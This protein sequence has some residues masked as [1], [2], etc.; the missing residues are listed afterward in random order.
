MKI[1]FIA[2]KYE[3]GDKNRGLSYEYINFYDTLV[4]MNGGQNQVI[5]FPVD[6]SMKE[7]GR[8]G[9]NK[10]LLEV[11]ARERSDLCFFCLSKDEIKQETIQKIT[12]ESGAVTFNWFTD[13]HWRFYNFSRHWAPYFNWVTTTDPKAI[14]KYHN[15]GYKNVIMSQWAC[16]HFLYKPLNLP[17]IYD[18]TFVG[19]PHG[20]RKKIINQIKKAG[21]NIACFGFGWPNGYVSFDQMLQIFSQSSININMTNSS[22][23]GIIKSVASVFFKKNYN[24]KIRLASPADWLDNIKFILAKRR[25]QFKG[26]NCE[27]PG[28]GSF[29]LTQDADG[30]RECYSDG[31]E[32]VIFKNTKDLIAKI[33]YYLEHHQEREAIAMAGYKR[34]MQDH[35]YEK[36]FNE[37][38]EKLNLIKKQ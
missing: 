4:K 31:K 28:C 1:I 7:F 30:L 5:Y 25:N 3:Y 38:F 34:T 21:I 17:K 27:V 35:T 20:N 26:R 10:K 36:R 23:S 16:N 8:E 14:E 12:K 32:V 9:A 22:T 33:R 19:Q 24:K 18:V 6:Q 29:L 2:N 15:I 11:V 37:I 13:D